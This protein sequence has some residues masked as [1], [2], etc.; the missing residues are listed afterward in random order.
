MAH[1]LVRAAASNALLAIR[2]KFLHAENAH[3]LFFQCEVVELNVLEKP[4]SAQ[5]SYVCLC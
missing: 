1:V 5:C 2:R 3:F 4:R